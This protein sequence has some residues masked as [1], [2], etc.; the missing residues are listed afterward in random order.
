MIELTY[1]KSLSWGYNKIRLI[2][3]IKHLESQK[4]FGDQKCGDYDDNCPA[5]RGQKLIELL[6]WYKELLD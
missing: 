3:F 6:H 2:N 1:M 5:C 4:G